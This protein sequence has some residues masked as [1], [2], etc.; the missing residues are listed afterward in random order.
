MDRTSL[1][2]LPVRLP[3]LTL[4]YFFCGYND[5][6]DNFAG[7]FARVRQV[8]VHPKHK[9]KTTFSVWIGLYQFKIMTCELLNAPTIWASNG[10]NTKRSKHGNL[11]GV[12]WRCHW[13]KLTNRTSLHQIE[14]FPAYYQEICPLSNVHLL[15]MWYQ[16][17]ELPLITAN[18][19]RHKFVKNQA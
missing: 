12:P 14:K 16:L 19:K 6:T 10:F 4:L 5:I 1:I 18:L 11:Y 3:V 2:E 13:K 17:K 7:K 9:E 15:A 8:A